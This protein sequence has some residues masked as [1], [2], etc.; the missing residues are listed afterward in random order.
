MT[1]HFNCPMSNEKLLALHEW[2]L[3]RLSHL[4]WIGIA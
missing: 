3:P 4:T 1:G 2:V